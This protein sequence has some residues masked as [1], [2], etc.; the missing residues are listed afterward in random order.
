MTVDDALTSMGRVNVLIAGRTGAGKSTLINA[1]F[2]GDLAR[3]GHGR[4]VTTGVTE[5]SKEGIPVTILD[6]RGLE[7]A[8]Y[9]ESLGQLEDEVARRAREPDAARHIHVAWVCIPE[10]GRRVEDAEIDLVRRLQRHVPVLVVI[11]KARADRGFRDEVARHLS[12]ARG[13]VRVRAIAEVLDDGHA[14]GA[15][16]IE[17][18]VIQTGALVPEA[19][20]TAFAAAQKASL[21]LK[22]AAADAV[23]VAASSKASLLG[24]VPLSDLVVVSLQRDMLSAISLAFG[25]SPT[26]LEALQPTF[27]QMLGHGVARGALRGALSM[28]PLLGT[29]LSM[30]AASASTKALGRAYAKRLSRLLESSIGREPDEDAIRRALSAG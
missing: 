22:R 9:R 2:R 30:L 25:L 29:P 6:T 4:P 20:R 5:I 27:A 13:F 19:R 3:T 10:D 1:V 7:M 17:E 12:G 18:L 26:T 21:S 16:G 14:L 11:T 28:L 23:I 8:A 24:A 15:Q